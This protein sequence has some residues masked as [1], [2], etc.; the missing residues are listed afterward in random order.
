MLSNPIQLH[1]T[2]AIYAEK[3][4]S[5]L[6]QKLIEAYQNESFAEVT[7]LI[8]QGAN[9][10]QIVEIDKERLIEVFCSAFIYP[11]QKAQKEDT[12]I[13]YLNQ[14]IQD[15][16]SFNFDQA[17][18]ELIPSTL[19]HHL[20]PTPE[21]L[22]WALSS[23]LTTL[24]ALPLPYLAILEGQGDILEAILSQG[25]N[26]NTLKILNC[27][28]DMNIAYC[29]TAV[30]E[31]SIQACDGDIIGLFNFIVLL[32]AKNYNAL[33]L[34]LKFGFDPRPW[35]QDRVFHNA[36]ASGH[37]ETSKIFLEEKKRRNETVNSHESP[38]LLGDDL[39]MTSAAKG[40]NVEVLKWLVDN[41][42]SVNK[43]GNQFGSFERFSTPFGIALSNNQFDAAQFL[44]DHG[45]EFDVEL[46]DR[47]SI[48]TFALIATV[49]GPKGIQFLLDQGCPLEFKVIENGS[50]FTWNLLELAM[51]THNES[52]IRFAVDL[53]LDINQ[54]V[55]DLFWSESTRNTYSIRPQNQ[56]E[57]S[58]MIDLFLELGGDQS[59]LPEP[60][61]IKL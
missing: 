41:G 11:A 48:N 2:K 59:L 15:D 33:D 39:I 35:Y 36:L 55:E 12:L 24:K 32:D 57:N 25:V 6:D 53:G 40:G 50:I 31:K 60:S 7:R 26:Y 1:S 13:P 52:N 37:T 42:Y 38:L 45:A 14:V 56:L 28:E 51:R 34:M 4:V 46:K 22:N 47:K 16:L 61:Q 30:E 49:G 58:Q 10:Q 19:C 54:C 20:S 18:K 44:L 9:S 5:T 29:L 27:P 17:Q 21:N 43:V 23:I 8:R 3:N